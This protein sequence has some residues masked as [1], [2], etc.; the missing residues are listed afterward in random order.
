ME[1]MPV[2]LVL[3][4]SGAGKSTMGRL[5]HE[6]LGFLHLEL[7]VYPSGADIDRGNL[8]QEWDEFYLR[9]LPGPLAAALRR[10]ARSAGAK[11]VIATFPS[12]V[13]FS[14]IQLGAADAE[15]MA[16]LVLYGTVAECLEAYLERET[17]LQRGLDTAHW[18]RHNAEAHARFSL[19]AYAQRRVAAFSAG[20]RKSFTSLLAEIKSRLA[21]HYT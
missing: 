14:E 19:P 1:T 11:G 21:M 8:R 20:T 5:V 7:D 18:H 16:V 17:R 15:A 2:L 9:N 10:R 4:L 6:N 12:S 13:V 3:G